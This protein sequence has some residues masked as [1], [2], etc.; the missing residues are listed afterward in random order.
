MRDFSRKAS[1]L[2]LK[3]VSE[4]RRA[5]VEAAARASSP[6]SHGAPANAV[7][8]ATLV[9]VISTSSV[10][11]SSSPGLTS[12]MAP[13][14][15][16]LMAPPPGFTLAIVSPSTMAGPSM[17]TSIT[18][19]FS[20]TLAP[21]PLKLER[22]NYSYWRS[23]ILPSIRAFDLEDFLIGTRPCPPRFLTL[24]FGEGSPDS[25]LQIG[26]MTPAMVA[27]R[28]NL[29]YLI[30]MRT[31]Q[32]LMSWLLSSITESML[33]HVIHCTSSSKIW[34]T[35]PQ[36]LPLRQRLEYYNFAFNFSLQRRVILLFKTIFFY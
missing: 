11:A 8:P 24:Q 13:P 22:E 32:A 28:V 10:F 19:P 9:L 35:L 16:F 20:T 2:N 31:D 21:I 15:G 36:L 17:A 27:Q 25:Q 30:W 14:P 33:G 34:L 26:S 6:A 3:M 5:S 18:A 7:N 23:L 29:E 1:F 12:S 4:L